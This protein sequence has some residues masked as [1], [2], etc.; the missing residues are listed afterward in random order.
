MDK[1]SC[2]NKTPYLI[3]QIGSFIMNLLLFELFYIT[4]LFMSLKRI[5]VIGF[6]F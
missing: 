4:K 1:T 2:E 3:A 5:D 6:R